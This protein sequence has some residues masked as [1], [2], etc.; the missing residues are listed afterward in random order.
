MK[1]ALNI[2]ELARRA[3]VR[4]DTVRYYERSGLLP[5]APR[6]GSGYRLYD[7]EAVSLLR[8]IR[9]A[10]Q[11]GFTLTEVAELLELRRS[12]DRRRVSR[13]AQDK[14]RDT[15]SRIAHLVRLR[16]VLKELVQRC[17]AG[18]DLTP[19]PILEALEDG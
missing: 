11:L 4:V 14:L 3:G 8:F 13:L 1:T 6:T 2:G 12:K 18:H 17:A 5:E 15:E 16:D 9:N 10:K 19:C 7:E